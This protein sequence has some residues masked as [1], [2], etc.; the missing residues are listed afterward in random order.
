[1]LLETTARNNTTGAILRLALTLFVQITLVTIIL[2]LDPM[3]HTVSLSDNDAFGYYALY[4]THQ[5]Q[6]TVLLVVEL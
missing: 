2:P 3:L 6:I 4:A 1:M 5:V